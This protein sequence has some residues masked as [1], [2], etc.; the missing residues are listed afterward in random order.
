[1]EATQNFSHP[2]IL[3][4]GVCNLCNWFVQFVIKR[5]KKAIFKFAALNSPFAG[6]LLRNLTGERLPTQLPDSVVLI[7]D[8]RI[9]LKSEAAI[10]ILEKLR[11]LRWLGAIYYFFPLKLRDWIYDFMASRRYR[12][13][14]RKDR[15]MIPSP[16][17]ANRF[18]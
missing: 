4:D 6:Q 18:L 12:W 16:E 15:C 5:D 9:Y 1:M 10:R 7:Q 8:E 17:T 13:F 2:I 3:F 14:G 11:G